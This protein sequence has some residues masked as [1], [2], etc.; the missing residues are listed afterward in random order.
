MSLNIP[1]LLT[2]LRLLAAPGVAVAFLALEAPLSFAVAFTLFV[3]A[4]VTDWLDGRLARSWNQESA[5]GAML[6]PIADKA[7]VLIALAALIGATGT[8]AWLFVPATAIIFREVLVSGL[9]E[10]MAARSVSLPVTGLAKW[11]TTV[12]LTAIAGLLLAFS[13][14]NSGTFLPGAVFALALAA[15]WLAAALTLASG[16]DYFRRSVAA[17]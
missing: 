2:V 17:L 7:L 8:G 1:T 3:A 11:K 16:W 4:S 14:P 15:L 10:F 9:R 13:V 5:L 12:Q 6:D